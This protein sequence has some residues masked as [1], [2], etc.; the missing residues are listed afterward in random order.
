M[1]DTAGTEGSDLEKELVEVREVGVERERGARDVG[2]SVNG[3]GIGR[4][5]TGERERDGGR[6]SGVLGAGVG[7]P[8]RVRVVGG[9]GRQRV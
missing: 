6:E 5:I 2:V 4:A 3:L 7:V 1:K 8:G 9:E